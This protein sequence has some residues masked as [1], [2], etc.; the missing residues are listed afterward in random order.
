MP[1]THVYESMISGTNRI[2]LLDEFAGKRVNCQSRQSTFWTIHFTPSG[3][4]SQDRP[5][6][7]TVLGHLDHLD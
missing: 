4:L 6:S 2:F 5:L 3:I 1:C 7:Q